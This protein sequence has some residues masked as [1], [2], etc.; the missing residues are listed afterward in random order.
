MHFGTSYYSG[1]GLNMSDEGQPLIEDGLFLVSQ[2]LGRFVD[3]RGDTT[4][5]GVRYS[6]FRWGKF[7]KYIFSSFIDS[8]NS[9]LVSNREAVVAEGRHDTPGSQLL[10]GYG[11]GV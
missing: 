1:H 10:D 6:D 5:D 9:I 3:S 11:L 8:R 7:P 4:I 2:V